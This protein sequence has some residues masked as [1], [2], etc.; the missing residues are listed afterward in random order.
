MFSWLKKPDLETRIAQLEADL[1]EARQGVLPAHG[2]ALS[3]HAE[4]LAGHAA[5]MKALNQGLAEL[6]SA[7]S[8]QLLDLHRWMSSTTQVVTAM[9]SVPVI[10]SPELQA[11]GPQARL[12]DDRVATSR[13][14]QIWTVM[15]W[16]AQA[17]VTSEI[18][19]SVVMPTRDRRDYLARAIASI[20]AQTHSNFELVIV[21]DG[22]TD[23]TPALLASIE[24]KRV[25]HFR[26]TGLGAASA[27]NIGLDAAQGEIITH[28]D[29]DN[30]M[31][32]NWLRSVSWGFSRWPDTE[33]LYGARI[34]E[35]P[36][37]QNGV[38]SG[39][40]P[41]MEF[42]PFDRARL[43]IGGY[44]DMNVIAHRA[45]LP[46]ARFDT[47]LPS[48]MDWDFILR[49]T[50]KRTPLE[51]PAI[52][53]LYSNYAPNRISDRK[54]RLR[55]NQ[56]VR[57]RVHT[58]RPMRVLACNA[59][60]PLPEALLETE[61]LAL[62]AAGAEISFALFAA[63]DEAVAEQN[64]DVIIAYAGSL[65]STERDHLERIGRPFALRAESYDP[66]TLSDPCCIGIW[67]AGAEPAGAE[68]AGA[69][70][71]GAEPGTGVQSLTLADFHDEISAAL[72]AWRVQ[73]Q[74]V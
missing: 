17:H 5:W 74:D 10:A 66:G 41:A 2:E 49:L 73:R 67:A 33:I 57:A 61:M 36:P 40:P 34:V 13:M 12:V 18:F 62:E 51:L 23:D 22:S 42:Q 63:L 31:D 70:P 58:T 14:L 60:S 64:P 48:S 46:E 15:R 24:D 27:R 30:L 37:A 65:A 43:E 8:A 68:P 69:E 21:D 6:N 50:A 56:F 54:N 9:S 20:L 28:F 29:D 26:T 44:I 52:A 25:R 35:D 1:Q 45:G 71:A 19:I 32:P 53:C 47:T 3:G 7:H 55:E 4:T 39:A 72:V 59:A 38:P 16:L 11:I